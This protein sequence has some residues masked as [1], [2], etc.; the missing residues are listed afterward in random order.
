MWIFSL[1]IVTILSLG[2]GTA[3][4][5]PV[6]AGHRT[7][8]ASSQIDINGFHGIRN[9]PSGSGDHQYLGTTAGSHGSQPADWDQEPE[10][11]NLGTEP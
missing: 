5:K 8:I 4:A 3:M 7:Q 11:I 2:A 6:P 10:A 9:R 1:A